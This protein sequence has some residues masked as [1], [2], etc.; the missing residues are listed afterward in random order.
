[1]PLQPLQPPRDAYIHA[2]GNVTIDESAQI[3]P[4]VLL[5]ADTGSQIV[6]AAGVC[7]GMGTIL[8]AQQGILAVEAG[9]I[10]G[11]GVLF[12]GRGKIG[13]NACVG[14]VVTILNSSIG[15]GQVVPPGSLIGEAVPAE[16]NGASGSVEA[17]APSTQR[18]EAETPVPPAEPSAPAAGRVVEPVYGQAQLSQLRLRLFSHRQSFSQ[19]TQEDLPS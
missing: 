3:A 4:G 11:A 2:S 14:S 19:P 18:A 13:A 12:I 1:M 15:P 8:H 17:S 7:I 5:Q 10:L 6:I 16:L 9:A